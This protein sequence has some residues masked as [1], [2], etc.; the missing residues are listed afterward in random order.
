MSA[1]LDDFLPQHLRR[2]RKRLSDITL[3]EISLVTLPENPGAMAVLHKIAP[4]PAVTEAI[5]AYIRATAEAA[6]AATLTKMA[7]YAAAADAALGRMTAA[8]VHKAAQDG[9]TVGEAVQ[10]ARN[11]A[12]HPPAF[13]HTALRR[14]GE[15][16]EPDGTETTQLQLALESDAGRWIAAALTGDWRL[17]IGR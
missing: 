3:S 8:N 13:W 10:D 5:E 1:D 16:L 6:V 7:G 11:G 12:E 15:Q 9:P 4:E 2:Q 14:L 17:L